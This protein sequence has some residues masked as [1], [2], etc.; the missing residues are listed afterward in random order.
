MR[1]TPMEIVP[2]SVA[3]RLRPVKFD[4]TTLYSDGLNFYMKLHLDPFGF[5]SEGREIQIL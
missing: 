3:G 2:D 5:H 1:L 4:R